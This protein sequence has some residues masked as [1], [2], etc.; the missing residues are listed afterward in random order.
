VAVEDGK[1]VLFV[2]C[3]SSDRDVS[4]ALKYLKTRFPSVAAWQISVTGSKD[5][6]SREGIRVATALQL[7]GTLV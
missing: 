3:K 1:P 7:L 5:Y 2:E 6:V 4:P